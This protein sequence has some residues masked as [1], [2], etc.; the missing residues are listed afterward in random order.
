MWL[1][2]PGRPVVTLFRSSW[3]QSLGRRDNRRVSPPAGGKQHP[4]ACIHVCKHACMCVNTCASTC[5]LCVHACVCGCHAADRMQNTG[6]CLQRCPVSVGPVTAWRGESFSLSSAGSGAR[7]ESHPSGL[8]VRSLISPAAMQRGGQLT[9]QSPSCPVSGGCGA[10]RDVLAKAA[11]QKVH[12]VQRPSH[13][14]LCRL[15]EQDCPLVNACPRFLMC[16]NSP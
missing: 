13:C 6:T 16:M 3:C 1:W 5:A 14:H 12:G 7:T 8:L 15:R 2:H 4:C 10:E 9:S 11:G